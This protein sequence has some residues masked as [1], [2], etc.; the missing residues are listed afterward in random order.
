ML[1]I[2][3]EAKKNKTVEL[4]LSKCGITQLPPEIGELKSLQLLVLGRYSS[5]YKDRNHFKTLP[6][7]IGQL[8]NL[9]RL[10]VINNELEE[11]PEEIGHL[12]NLTHLNLNY[13]LLKELPKEIGNL[14]NLTQLDLKKNQLGELPREIGQLRDLAHLNMNFNELK[15]LP[16]EISQLKNLTQ[17]YMNF[18]SFKK[19]PVDITRLTH[20]AQLDL[21]KNQL[22]ELPREF[23]Q[24]RNLFYLNLSGNQL[25]ELPEE[26]SQ[27]DNLIYF[28]ISSNRIRELP[29]GIIHLNNLFYLDI[30]ANHLRELPKEIV[31]LEK[32][33][34]LELDHNPLNFPPV[35]IV[36]QGS[37][38]IMD[39]LKRM[40]D[41][42]TLYE[43]K[44]LIL[45]QG[46]V[47]KTCLMRRLILD[48]YSDGQPTT[49]GIDIHPWEITAPDDAQTRMTLN[50]WDFGGQEI[51][52]ATHQ[53]F[54]TQ[55]S[56]YILAWDA[57]QEEEYGRI[58]YWLKTIETFAEDSPILIVMN[59]CDERVKYLNFKELKNRCPQLVVSG[60][61]SAKK[62]T[63][64]QELRNFI[65]EQAWK[66]PLMGTFW[67][68]S[69]L[70]VRRALEIDS[71]YQM[72]YQEYLELCRQYEIEEN[73][74]RT[75]SRYLHDLGI[76]LHFQ[77]DALLTETIILKPEWGTD[78]VYKVL[79]AKLVQRR[80][81]ILYNGDLPGI[82]TDRALYP[83][84]KY[85]TI[86]RLMA[87]FELAFP[88]S[89]GNCHIVTEL[90]PEREVEYVW[91][92][93]EDYL[94]FEYHYE[95]LPAGL[96]TRL[97]VRMHEFVIERN[98]KHLCW[99]EGAYLTY[100]NSQ[101]MMKINPYTKISTIQIKGENRRK[102]LKIIRSHFAALHETIRKI[103][104]REKVPCTCTH[105]CPYCFDYNF[106]LK[107]EEK[108]KQTQTCQISVEEVNIGKLLNAIEAPEVRQERVTEEMEDQY[109][110]SAVKP[111]PPT[112]WY[113]KKLW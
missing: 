18:N 65:R 7:E 49:E 26:I 101:A 29:T 108:G 11:V 82:W 106:L 24:L 42:Q 40:E 67:P 80:N 62:G 88:I 8:K 50:V 98:T 90:L 34:R 43:G 1:E 12:R 76:I 91:D 52:H 111:P 66:L 5:G 61:V 64:V 41:G 21:K 109:P 95:F 57:R 30:S 99:R 17:L 33:K 113:L 10:Y 48:K 51:Y 100:G 4:N 45:G 19:F 55:R 37:S 22:T 84:E 73:E 35:E 2:I 83:K 44:L 81:G 58:D 78:A 46:G 39:Y 20:L 75:L 60:R 53:F 54:L 47:G 27:L 6:K 3:Q 59:K 89:R 68:P 56:L 63:G 92:L 25:K 94:Q 13:N 107:C 74:A 85:A 104:F 23:G 105:G 103:H 87:N 71:R 32:L 97:I 112:K 9:T 70:E 15:S 69:W 110:N 86:L 14:R 77:D 16:E 31:R 102:F 96:M 72:P 79:D 28:H 36:N 93:E 38:A